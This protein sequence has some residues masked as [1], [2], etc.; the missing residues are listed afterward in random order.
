MGAAIDRAVGDVLA[1]G[2]PAGLARSAVGV[3]LGQLLQ[4]AVTAE[5]GEGATQTQVLDAL[6][7]ACGDALAYAVVLELLLLLLLVA[8][9]DEL[10]VLS[11]L[12]DT[13]LERGPGDLPA[14]PP[15]RSARRRR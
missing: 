8:S 6:Q 15:W 12:P 4:S 7:D 2:L 9:L 10:Q 13:G 3:E 11:G 14:V 1:R 5:I